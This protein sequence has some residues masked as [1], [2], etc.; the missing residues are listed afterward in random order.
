M[1]EVREQG[2]G[3]SKSRTL[4]AR[5]F[6][7]G[8]GGTL[9][10]AVSFSVEAQQPKRVPRIGFL[11]LPGGPAWQEEEFLKGLRDLG[12]LDGQNII[13]EYRWAAGKM[14][15]LPA[16]A[17]ELVRLKVDLIVVRTT[18]VVQAARDATRTIPIVMLS[19]ADPV[20]I[21]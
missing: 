7:L 5:L 6:A 11:G 19:A 17:A 4:T 8:F 9:L 1:T 21:G 16:L 12:Y 15:R 3:V 13:I 20:G 2:S 18:P 10:L 14:D